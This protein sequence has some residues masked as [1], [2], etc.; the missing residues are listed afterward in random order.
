MP[1]SLTKEDPTVKKRAQKSEVFF[2]VSSNIGTRLGSVINETLQE[3]NILTQRGAQRISDSYQ[4]LATAKIFD[5]AGSKMLLSYNSESADDLRK[6][7]DA[8]MQTIMD[9][10]AG[11]QGMT[12]LE[13]AGV[14][15]RLVKSMG[16]ITPEKSEYL[17]N[18][19]EVQNMAKKSDTIEDDDNFPDEDIVAMIAAKDNEYSWTK[20]QLM[21]ITEAKDD[22][23]KKRRRELQDLMGDG[24]STISGEMKKEIKAAGKAAKLRKKKM[25]VQKI[26]KKEATVTI[27]VEKEMVKRVSEGIDME[28]VIN[29]QETKEG[30]VEDDK[31]DE[32][33][34]DGGTA[35]GGG[36]GASSPSDSENGGS[37]NK[38][39]K[40]RASPKPNCSGD[41]DIHSD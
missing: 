39:Q 34:A 37:P 15:S 21:H 40:R 6:K 35:E 13:R 26:M 25:I 3:N 38:K 20:K 33:K 23:A 14:G 9:S 8:E 32:G 2:D 12:P 31:A 10:C 19:I 5:A 24:A 36:A 7:L 11:F 30:Q 4:L 27:D 28:W 16:R 22:A 18:L 29:L 1:V 17:R 41:E